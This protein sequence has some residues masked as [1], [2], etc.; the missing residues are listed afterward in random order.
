V[1]RWDTVRKLAAESAAHPELG[2]DPIWNRALAKAHAATGN[3]AEAEKA[4]SRAIAMVPAEEAGELRREHLSVVH[5]SK[6]YARVLQ[7]TDD[8][9]AKGRK[10]WWVYEYRGMAKA[11]AKD[12]TAAQEFDAALGSLDPEK[13]Y[14][15]A[16]AVIV[17]IARTL[18]F[19][20]ALKRV[21]KWESTSPRW[22][23]VA[24]DLCFQKGDVAGSLARLQPVEAEAE[25]LPADLRA[26]FYK[27]LAQSYHQLRPK[28]DFEKSIAAYQ[29]YLKLQPGDVTA[30]NNLAYILAEEISPGRPQEAKQYSKVAYEIARG[31]RAG[32]A[33][34][35]IFDTHGWVLVLNGEA[36]LDEGIRVLRQV[37]E[38]FP[39]LEAH[40]HLGEAQL[41]KN[42]GAEAQE[43]F[44]AALAM[45]ERS[46]KA[47][48][49]F[50]ETLEP[51]IRR[52]LQSAKALSA[53]AAR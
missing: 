7:L 29:Q 18:G 1:R 42:R 46:K 11:G 43:Q 47:K 50:D 16:Q 35:R 41:R 23:F 4:I 53:A 40:Y 51:K 37:V 6:N 5:Q 36:D 48:Q 22:R 2:K 32:D 12:K 24:A 9:L 13:Q 14:P 39:I 15:A 33:K 45:I 34:G 10:D 8:M 28:P 30:L 31:W 17:T 3:F 21:E 49:P 25:K 27:A 52:G 38:D 19:D 26:S 44:N 20:E